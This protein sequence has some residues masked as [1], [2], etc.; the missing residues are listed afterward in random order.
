MK[1]IKF[2]LCRRKNFLGLPPLESKI[3]NKLPLLTTFKVSLFIDFLFSI[4]FL[5]IGMILKDYFFFLAVIHGIYLLINVLIYNHYTYLDCRL[6]LAI[7][8]IKLYLVFGF[9]MTFVILTKYRLYF[10]FEGPKY[11]LESIFIILKTVE[12]ISICYVTWSLFRRIRMLRNKSS[13][14]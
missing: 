12:D 5:A 7:Y 8:L 9:Q 11:P 3:Y 14:S 10:K 1:I 13:N 4:F 2:I 6:I